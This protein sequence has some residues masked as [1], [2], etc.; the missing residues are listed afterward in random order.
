MNN[1]GQIIGVTNNWGQ[2]RNYS[3][4]WVSIELSFLAFEYFNFVLG[5]VR[6]N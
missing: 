2:S 6:V 1:W 5:N 3:F 4:R